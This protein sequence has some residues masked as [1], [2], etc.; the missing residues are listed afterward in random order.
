MYTVVEILTFLETVSVIIIVII[1]LENGLFFCTPPLFVAPARGSPLEFLDE[2][3][4][5]KLEG[6]RMG[7]PY[8]ENSTILQLF[9]YDTPV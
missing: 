2:T 6:S 5:Q 4:R 3:Y 7:L 1:K 9:L 8:G